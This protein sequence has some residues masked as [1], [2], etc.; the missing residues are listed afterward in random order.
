[1]LGEQTLKTL[2][3]VKPGPH[4][5]TINDMKTSSMYVCKSLWPALS[6]LAG[7]RK[8]ERRDSQ[9]ILASGARSVRT[10]ESQGKLVDNPSTRKISKIFFSCRVAPLVRD[11]GFHVALAGELM[12]PGFEGR[13]YCMSSSRSVQDPKCRWHVEPKDRLDARR[14]ARTS[15]RTLSTQ[16]IWKIELA[17]GEYCGWVAGSSCYTAAEG[18]RWAK[19]TRSQRLL[20]SLPNWRSPIPTDFSFGPIGD[21]PSFPT[22]G[23]IIPLVPD[24]SFPSVAS[25]DS[26]LKEYLRDSLPTRVLRPSCLLQANGVWLATRSVNWHP[27]SAIIAVAPNLHTSHCTTIAASGIPKGQNHDR[28][29]RNTEVWTL[30]TLSVHEAHP[31][32]GK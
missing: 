30:E 21:T 7:Y 6:A 18:E 29:G 23:R 24:K 2:S 3:R 8:T 10:T 11:R 19:S 4:A 17:G 26:L 31:D 14:A 9:D 13:H 25:G 20:R 15:A 27:A 32:S 16:I 1:M 22:A 28:L 5:E 12:R